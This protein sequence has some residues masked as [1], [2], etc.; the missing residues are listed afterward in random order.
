MFN[1]NFTSK[2]ILKNFTAV[3]DKFNDLEEVKKVVDGRE[4][5]CLDL[6]DTIINDVT[7]LRIGVDANMGEF[8]FLLKTYS[9][10]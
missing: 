10:E 4:F 5:V 9:V 6:Q 1:V 7:W 8:D 3:T 2:V